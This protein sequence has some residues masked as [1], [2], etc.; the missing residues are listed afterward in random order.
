ML[1]HKIASRKGLFCATPAWP[2]MYAPESL[3]TL[4]FFFPKKN[5][6]H[7]DT[8]YDPP[9]ALLSASSSKERL[10]SRPLLHQS[11]LVQLCKE[12]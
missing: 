3:Q 7:L 6:P 9:C 12:I 2:I 1:R 10:R 5:P 8:A 4:L 11:V